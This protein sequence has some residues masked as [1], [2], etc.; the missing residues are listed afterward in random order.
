MIAAIRRQTSRAPA[1]VAFGACKDL[2][3]PWLV[4]K[5]MSNVDPILWAMFAFQIKHFVCD[6]VLQTQSQIRNKGT[7][8][9]LAGF[10]HAATHAV[11]SLPALLI[12]G[13]TPLTIAILMFAEFVIHYHVDWYKA[14]FDQGRGEQDNLYWIIFGVD[15]LVHQLTYIGMIYF[16]LHGF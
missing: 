1:R 7:Y 10:G 13:A 16:V 2:V 5:G 8:G 12:L 3:S 6:F 11:G 9:H 15:Q 4:A 14:R